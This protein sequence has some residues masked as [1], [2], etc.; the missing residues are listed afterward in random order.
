MRTS[1]IDATA[2]DSREV[3]I[4]RVGKRLYDKVFREYTKKQWNVL[5]HWPIMMG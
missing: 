1:D 2:R 4:G 3:G 5:R